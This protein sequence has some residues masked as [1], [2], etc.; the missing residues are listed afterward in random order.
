M[1]Y[2]AGKKVKGRKIHA[3]VDSEGLPVRVV[4]Q[5]FKIA[6]GPVWCS[7]GSA[8]AS[9]GS[10]IWADRGYNAWQVD[11]AVAKVLRL[12][13][14]RKAERRREGL[15]RAAAPL[16]GRAH[17]FLVRA[18][19]EACQGFRESRRNPGYLRHPRF[20]PARPQA[21]CPGLGPGLNTVA[22]GE[23]LLSDRLADVAGAYRSDADA[24]LAL[25]AAARNLD[26]PAWA[27]RGL[28]SAERLPPTM[29]RAPR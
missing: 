17:L 12:C 29:R 1:G 19:P 5:P 28:N 24:P 22:G 15:R 7:T 27:V 6:T 23:R 9:R 14:N 8:T 2:D 3:L 13:L 10:N 18:Q 4:V 16:G 11:A 26:T 25:I 21:S 20:D